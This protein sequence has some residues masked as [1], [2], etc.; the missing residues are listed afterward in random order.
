M[1][2]IL[3]FEQRSIE[4]EA[5]RLEKFTAS[6][7]Y[8]IAKPKGLGEG[9]DTYIKKKVADFIFG[10]QEEIDTFAMQWG[11]KYEPVAREALRDELKCWDEH[12][13]AGL[14]VNSEYPN[15]ACSPD[16][17][18]VSQRYGVEIKCPLSY[19]NHTSFLFCKNGSDLKKENDQYY[20][21][22]QFSLMI[23]EYKFW[24][25]CSYH[26]DAAT[27]N[28]DFRLHYFEV[29][30]DYVDIN[31]LAQR[32]AEADIKRQIYKDDLI[33]RLGFELNF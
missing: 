9:G 17:L 2:H 7:I 23:S 24:Y 6:E 28:G 20:W 31:F 29:Y 4:W 22:I 15:C 25:F 13:E 27:A 5:A 1:V 10:Q 33:S 12:T 3:N 16:D 19:T 30:P 18:N 21:Q 8:K 26:P 11:R 32:I 14:I